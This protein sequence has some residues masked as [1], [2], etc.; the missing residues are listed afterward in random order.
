MLSSIGLGYILPFL[1]VITVVVF[2]HELGHFWVARLCGVRVDAFSIGFGRALTSWTDKKGTVWKI[3][4]LPMGGYVKFYGDESVASNPDADKLSQLSEEDKQEIFHFKPLWQRAAIVAAGPFA[5]FLL[6]IVIFTG[7]FSI[8]GERVVT[9]V[10]NEVVAESA[11]ARAGFQSGD[12]IL[13]VNGSLVDSFSDVQRVV[14][15]NPETNLEF[16]VNRGGVETLLLARPDLRVEKDRFGNVYN[17]GRL[18]ISNANDPQYIQH[19]R[20][21]PITAIGMGVKETNF[22]ITQT[23]V[24]IGRIIVGRE[25]AD[26]LGGPIRIAQIS[27]EM[28]SIGLAAFINLVALISVSIGLINL[29]PVPMLDGGHLL[30]YSFEAVLGRPLPEKV[31]ETSMRIGL[32]LVLM[33]FIFVTWNDLT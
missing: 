20:H 1:A 23:F 14:K 16:M 9:P 31:Q 3:G 15:L 7:L 28:A 33:L 26:A 10:V 18:G 5:N 21:D 25:S 12:V 24:S 30:F 19:V 2:F 17:V 13:A 27:G 22:I 6:A 4:W 11:A 8:F 29:F 32:A